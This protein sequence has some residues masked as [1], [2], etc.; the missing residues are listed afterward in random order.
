MRVFSVL[1][2]CLMFSLFSVDRVEAYGV[3]PQQM[4]PVLDETFK[5]QNEEALKT[6]QRQAA[7]EAEREAAEKRAKEE[8]EKSAKQMKT[9]MYW[10][11]G[12]VVAFVG[13]RKLRS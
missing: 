11:I 3:A 8:K 5:K 1:V 6:A 9:A 7:R 12:M 2:I 13:Y 4:K 10:G